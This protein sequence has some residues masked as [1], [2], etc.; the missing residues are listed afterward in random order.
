MNRVMD[1][2]IKLATLLIV[3]FVIYNFFVVAVIEVLNIL[4]IAHFSFGLDKH[5][6]L[7]HII[8][9]LFYIIIAIVVIDRYFNIKF[10][11]LGENFFLKS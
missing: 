9:V 6:V 11:K 5:F 10:D 1:F 3:V 2:R 7:T 8:I 4:D